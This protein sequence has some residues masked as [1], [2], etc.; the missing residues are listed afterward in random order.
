MN[1]QY[2]NVNGYCGKHG[3]IVR[4]QKYSVLTA[5]KVQNYIENTFKREKEK[6]TN[7]Y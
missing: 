4:F 5:F 2:W 3:K 6:T 1:I 7:I